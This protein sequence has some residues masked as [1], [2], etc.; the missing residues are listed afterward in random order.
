MRRPFVRLLAVAAGLAV[1]AAI[2]ALVSA[3]TRPGTP[4]APP[5]PVSLRIERSGGLS[6]VVSQISD[7]P[8]LMIRDGTAYAAGSLG[9]AV[10]GSIV[11]LASAPIDARTAARWVARLRELGVGTRTDWGPRPSDVGAVRFSLDD[12]SGH[13]DVWVEGLGDVPASTGPG[14]AANTAVAAAVNEFRAWV[15]GR[16]QQVT[17]S[18]LVRFAATPLPTEPAPSTILDWPAGPLAAGAFEARGLYSATYVCAV[19][20]ESSTATVMNVLDGHPGQLLWRD[21]G[22][23]YEVVLRP[24][25]PGE[26]TCADAYPAPHA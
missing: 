22:A 2:V 12:G 5:A 11:P 3:T 26:T 21:A 25:L 20:D 13:V 9:D 1:A 4:E 23:L 14:G 7:S 15:L 10:A 8:M 17:P 19:L 16:G 24:L 6:P 18:R